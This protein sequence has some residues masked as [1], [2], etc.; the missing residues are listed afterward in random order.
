MTEET[1]RDETVPTDER[2]GAVTGH[3][4]QGD[5]ACHQQREKDSRGDYVDHHQAIV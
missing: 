1:L 5:K 4:G 2:S 3:E